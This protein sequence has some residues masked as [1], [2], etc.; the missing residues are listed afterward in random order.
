VFRDH[1]L[2]VL[3]IVDPVV[4]LD[5]LEIQIMVLQEDCMVVVEVEVMV[6]DQEDLLLVVMDRKVL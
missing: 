1:R 4:L 6:V 5:H 3:V 2:L